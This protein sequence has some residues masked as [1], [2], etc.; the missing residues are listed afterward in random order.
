VEEVGEIEWDESGQ[1]EEFERV[2]GRRR[3]SRED[4]LKSWEDEFS[5]GITNAN[6][7]SA[8]FRKLKSCTTCETKH[9]A[10]LAARA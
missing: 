7:K 8:I 5:L 9:I 10:P 4:G 6:G 3:R 2:E 1:E